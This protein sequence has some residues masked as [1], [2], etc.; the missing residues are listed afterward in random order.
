MPED[1]EDVATAERYR[2]WTERYRGTTCA[3][4]VPGR[5]PWPVGRVEFRDGDPDT[6]MTAVTVEGGPGKQA[7]LV[8]AP[9]T[10][11]PYAHGRPGLARRPSDDPDTVVS[12]HHWTEAG[13]EGDG[14]WRWS[15]F[16]FGPPLPEHVLDRVR[17]SITWQRFPCP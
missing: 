14:A 16:T 9:A 1:D 4:P 6:G 12:V 13:A 15:L 7:V 17:T 5:W 11:P 3:L 2:R 8:R 10:D